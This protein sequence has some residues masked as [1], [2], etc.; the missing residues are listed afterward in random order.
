MTKPAT[1]DRTRSYA[2]VHP[3][4][5]VFYHQDHKAFDHN[6]IEILADE[7]APAP[8][9]GDDYETWKAPRLRKAIKERT[10]KGLSVGVP[11]ADM[12]ETLRGLDVVP[13]TD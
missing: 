10:G 9:E 1:L 4:D 12:I 6:G 2:E 11:K 5:V 3:A 8:V 7:E 13:A